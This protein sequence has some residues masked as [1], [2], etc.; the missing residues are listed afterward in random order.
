MYMLFIWILQDRMKNNCIP[1]LG[2][3]DEELCCKVDH[4]SETS[5]LDHIPK[6]AGDPVP[7]CISITENSMK[8][9]S[10]FVDVILQ[11]TLTAFQFYF[12]IIKKRKEFAVVIGIFCYWYHGRFLPLHSFL[13][14]NRLAFLVLDFI[15][16]A[17]KNWRNYLIHNQ[18][19]I[20]TLQLFWTVSIS[21][22]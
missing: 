13:Q 15:R 22:V 11:L 16:R 8:F 1:P 18:H 19:S 6:Q 21:F 17:L 2:G 9:S 3:F 20:L 5:P 7:R 14:I 10:S 12:V 4:G